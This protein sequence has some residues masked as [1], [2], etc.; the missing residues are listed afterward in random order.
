MLLFFSAS[1]QEYQT[2]LTEDGK[3]AYQT[4]GKGYPVLIINGGPGM[5]SEGF[6]P[7]AKMLSENNTTVIYDQRGTGRSEMDEVNSASI[8][9]QKMVEDIEMLR[10]HLGYDEWIVLGH[11]FG[12]ML[13]YAYTAK[14]PDR[15]TAMIQSHSGGLD[16][17]VTHGFDITSRLSATERDSLAHYSLKI[18]LGDQSEETALK[19]AEFLAPAYLYDKSLALK[20]AGRLTQGNS[21]INSLVWR[22]M[23]STGFNVSS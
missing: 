18:Q 11:S 20:I 17:D 9:L 7:L 3:L 19:R 4:F 12:G 5:H 22:D 13:A 8:S 16:L 14:H 1:G 21:R 15:V 23:Q 6:I 10:E 2:I